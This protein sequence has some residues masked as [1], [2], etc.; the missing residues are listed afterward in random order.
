VELDAA[1]DAPSFDGREGLVKSAGRVGRQIVLRNPDALGLRIVDIDEFTHA[2][3][4]VFGGAPLGD[5]AYAPLYRKNALFTGHAAPRAVLAGVC[6][7][8]AR[9]EPKTAAPAKLLPLPL[10]SLPSG[11]GYGRCA[12]PWATLEVPK[13]PPEHSAPFFR[14][15]AGHAPTAGRPR[16][17]V[18]KS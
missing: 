12:R 10:V 13:S 2:L 14:Y 15:A 16:T 1:Q 17:R 8:H 6:A 3:G 4:V 18:Q 7:L 11:E 5:L 9:S